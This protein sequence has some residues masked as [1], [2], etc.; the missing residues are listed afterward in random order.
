LEF[1][2][3]EAISL[4]LVAGALILLGLRAIVFEQALTLIT[5]AVSLVTGKYL[6]RYEQQIIE[7][8]RGRDG[9]GED[10]Y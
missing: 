4:I 9:D 2:I 7:R 5:I 10:E 8:I 1:R 3:V 6:G